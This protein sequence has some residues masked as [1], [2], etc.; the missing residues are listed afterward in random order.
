[1]SIVSRPASKEYRDNWPFGEKSKATPAKKT[2]RERLDELPRYML[3]QDTCDSDVGCG[4]GIAPKV[5]AETPF[6]YTSNRNAALNERRDAHLPKT[7]VFVRLA[8][9]ELMLAEVD[10]TDGKS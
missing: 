7:T 5:V 6:A 4:A 2:I 10:A 8:D 9:V 1:M 3:D